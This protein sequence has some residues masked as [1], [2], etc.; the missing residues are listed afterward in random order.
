MNHLVKQEKKIY[1]L[2][3][4][5]I[6]LTCLVARYVLKHNNCYYCRDKHNTMPKTKLDSL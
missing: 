3:L 4:Y 2:W 6:H 5:E 1:R